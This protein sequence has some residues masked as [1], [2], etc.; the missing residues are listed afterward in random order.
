[1]NCIIVDDDK[2]STKII[3]E[4]IRK[5]S[6]LNL[7]CSFDNAITAINFLSSK[8]GNIQLV[9]LDIEMPEMNGL[10]F[11]RSIDAAHLQIIIYSSQEKYALESYEYNVTDYLLKPLTYSRFLK[12]INKAEDNLNKPSGTVPTEVKPSA[13]G[14]E[15]YLRINNSL[16]CVKYEDIVYLKAMENYV[17]L[18][19]SDKCYTVHYTMRDIMT[20][21][22]SELFLRVHRSFAVNARKIKR[23]NA[24][25]LVLASNADGAEVEIP[26]GKSFRKMVMFNFNML[27]A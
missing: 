20:K 17:A 10:E 6:K 18:N 25:K 8:A 16:K 24:S 21:L 11:I 4:H 23:L 3:S 7:I 5:T 26:I 1:M 22:P 15:I 13:S 19:L 14:E 12:A 9:F 27:D 2:L